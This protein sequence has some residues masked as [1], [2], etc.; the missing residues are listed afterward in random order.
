[1]TE[2]P[3]TTETWPTTFGAICTVVGGLMLFGGCL[4]F[5]GMSDLAQLHTAI[6]FGEG[7]LSESIVEA[8]ASH[9]PP[10]W[11]IRV[12]TIIQILLSLMLLSQG[13]FLIQRVPSSIKWLLC[14]SWLYIA[15]SLTQVVVNWLPRME[16]VQTNS[17]IQGMFLAQLLISIPLY[18]ALPVFML[19]WLNKKRIKNE[20]SGWL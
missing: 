10:Y 13:L 19:Y 20:V 7:E 6:P 12:T 14:W 11:L 16:L 18:L 17:E 5:G 15:A 2:S 1:M 9:G 3:Q 4:S 8:L